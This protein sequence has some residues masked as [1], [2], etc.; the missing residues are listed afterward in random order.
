MIHVADREADIYPFMAVAVAEQERFVIRAA[1]DRVVAPLADLDG[2]DGTKLFHVA[3]HVPARMH[4]TIEL[5]ERATGTTPSQ[6]KNYPKRRA[7]TASVAFGGCQVVLRRPSG[8]SR[9]LPAQLTL[10]VVRVWEPTPLPDEPAVEWILVTTEPIDTDEQLAR[11]V[12]AY[13]ARWVI[14]EF[15]KALKTGCALEK[16][17][18]ES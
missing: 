4:R 11:V 6:R 15:F 8:A 5:S 7:R 17:Q 10:N 9:E 18:L 2:P 12:D 13:R 3:R 16:R 14:E 1:Q